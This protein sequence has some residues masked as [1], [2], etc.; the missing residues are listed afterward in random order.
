M[1]W[2][3]NHNLGE[4]KL[5]MWQ[6]PAPGR[7]WMSGSRMN[8][9]VLSGPSMDSDH[10][11]TSVKINFIITAK[12]NPLTIKTFRIHDLKV[13]QEIIL[14]RAWIPGLMW[15]RW[16]GYK[17]PGDS[18]TDD[19][20]GK[21]E[22]HPWWKDECHEALQERSKA[23]NRWCCNDKDFEEFKEQRKPKAKIFR[24]A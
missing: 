18:Q 6:P 10:Y 1:W 24:N 19:I 3:P 4:F 16:N 17:N 22:K 21:E 15:V 23:W 13:N 5:I 8:V 7:Q 2:F 9:R 11:L 20:F 14:E 12:R